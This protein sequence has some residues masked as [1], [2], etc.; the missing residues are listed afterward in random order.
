MSED[1]RGYLRVM[2]TSVE[3]LLGGKGQRRETRLA[4]LREFRPQR[5]VLRL[6]VAA[7]L[8][9]IGGLTAVTIVAWPHTFLHGFVTTADRA[10]RTL[11]LRDP[12]A[13]A[14][15]AALAG[16]GLALVVLAALPGRT[17]VEPLRGDD[18]LVITGV[19][20]RRLGTA[21]AATAVE[22][23]GVA[24]ASVRLRGRIRRRVIVH[25]DIVYPMPGN[26][27]ERIGHA[28]AVRLAEMEPARPRTVIVQLRWQRA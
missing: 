24:A 6:A 13:L 16:L 8:I 26:L 5:T 17:A 25:A 3:D 15:A 1:D 21:L 4:A 28:V 23:P 11:P 18:P 22:V 2:V 9:T 12:E 7:A 27:A 10:L 19:D 14:V 20:R